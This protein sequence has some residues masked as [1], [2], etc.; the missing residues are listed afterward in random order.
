MGQRILHLADLHLG[1]NHDYLGV[2]AEARAREV[3]TVLDRVAD[4]L[5]GPNH[6]PAQPGVG[7]VL[8]AGDLF[9]SP[10]PDDSIVERVVRSLGRITQAGITVI[11]VPGNHDE[12]THPDCVYHRWSSSWPG[13]L[14]TCTEPECVATLDL[15]GLSV[16]VVSCAFQQGRN[17]PSSRWKNP[18]PAAKDPHSRRI[19]LFHGTLDR[20]GGVITEG[21]RAFPL[22]FARLAKWGL[23][24]LAL[25]H[26]H[27]RESFREG[28]CLA[29]YPG[30][31]EGLSFS[32]PGAPVLTLVDLSKP[33]ASTQPVDARAAGIRIRDVGTV[34]IDLVQVPDLAALERLVLDEID[35]HRPPPILRV[36]LRGHAD[37][38]WAVDDLRKRLASKFLRLEIDA[39]EP[40]VTL[41]DW[42]ALATQ[43]TLEGIFVRRVL[44]E[45][46]ASSTPE[47]ERWARIAE[48]GLRALGRK[49]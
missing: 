16:D 6:G 33:T 9:D 5:L 23:D 40:T 14:V 3:D 43:R 8:I 34:E 45:R 49:R 24:Y 22:D 32:H 15:D 29:H 41:G 4:W 25:G 20:Y 10:R 19:G 36:S 26:I 35:D 13:T 2:D 44:E 27:K 48:A 47:D 17:E 21:E 38:P 31:I 12:L 1:A 46:A 18:L 37:F 30:P 42:E 11:T 39:E 28:N 7:A